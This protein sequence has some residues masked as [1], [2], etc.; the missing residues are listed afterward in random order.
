MKEASGPFARAANERSIKCT[1]RDRDDAEKTSHQ[2]NDG[3]MKDASGRFARAA[4]E[5][6]IKCTARDRDDAEKTTYVELKPRRK[7]FR[8]V[9]ALLQVASGISATTNTN[10]SQISQTASGFGPKG[11][12]DV[13]LGHSSRKQL[14]LTIQTLRTQSNNSQPIGPPTAN[15]ALGELAPKTQSPQRGRANTARLELERQTFPYRT[16]GNPLSRNLT[17]SSTSAPIVPE[18]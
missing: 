4:N 13:S 7:I 15:V 12:G 9:W 8:V 14:S 3:L 6:S 10:R 1:A 17:N 5:R 11:Q 2:R 16:R 18:T